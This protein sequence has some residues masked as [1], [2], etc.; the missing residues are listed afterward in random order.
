MSVVSR[1]AFGSGLKVIRQQVDQFSGNGYGFDGGA[2]MQ[3]NPVLNL[4]F[5][6]KNILAPHIKI[7]NEKDQYPLDARL[8][9]RWQANRKLMVAL[10]VN[11]TAHRTAKVR[12]EA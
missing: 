5:T 7:R 11:Q 2:M 3:I 10:D 9:S 8:G 12:F 1:F 4:G 6:L